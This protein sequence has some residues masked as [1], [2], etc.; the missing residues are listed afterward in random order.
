MA[1]EQQGPILTDEIRSY[2]GREGDEFS[3]IVP[4][5]LGQN[6]AIAAA[7]AEPNPLYMDE[8]FAKTTPFGGLIAPYMY[9]Q[10]A[11]GQFTHVSGLRPDGVPEGSGRA[12]GLPTPPIPLP[13]VMAG[14]TEIEYVR[15][16]RPGE[17]L[18]AKS[19]IADITERS[20]RSGPLVFQTNETTYR[21]DAGNP[22]V[23]V[24]GTSIAR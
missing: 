23:I 19:K 17:R 11:A 8:A 12:G 7:V 13:R 24:R 18:T 4:L 3:F 16:I 2:I 15:P 14:G 20:G 1:D 5:E 6:Y 10:A 21:D 22:V 9:F